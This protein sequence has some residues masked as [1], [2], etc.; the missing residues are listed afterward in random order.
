[1]T[2]FYLKFT[3]EKQAN[4]VLLT[5]DGAAKYAN[6]RIISVNGDNAPDGFHVNIETLPGEDE[7]LLFPFSIVT[8]FGGEAE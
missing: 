3:D 6:I 7:S 4:G 1:M 2:T 8:T 5:S